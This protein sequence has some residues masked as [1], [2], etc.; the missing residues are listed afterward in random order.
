MAYLYD[1]NM[2]RRKGNNSYTKQYLTEIAQQSATFA[3]MCRKLGIQHG[4]SQSYVKQRMR[5]LGVDFSHF[6]SGRGWA[7]GIPNTCARKAPD[8]IF[9]VRPVGSSRVHGHMLYRALKESGI[10]EICA[11]C[12]I[13]TVWNKKPLRFT[14]DHI[15]G[16]WLDSKKENLR[17]ICPNCDSQTD[18]YKNSR[19]KYFGDP[20]KVHESVLRL[21]GETNNGVCSDLENRR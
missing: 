19:R 8:K 1:T 3:D 16:N 9:C 15:D 7:K 13:G 4:G 12:G 20:K 18:T 5:I 14:V 21:N 11:V 6:R 17:F 10:P 2:G